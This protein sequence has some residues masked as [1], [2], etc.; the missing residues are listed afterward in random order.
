MHVRMEDGISSTLLRRLQSIQNAAALGHWSQDVRSHDTSATRTSLAADPPAHCV[1]VVTRGVQVPAQCCTS[2]SRQRL[3]TGIVIGQETTTAFLCQR[4]SGQSADKNC[5]WSSRVQSVRPC[6]V[7]RPVKCRQNCVL[8]LCVL[9]LSGNNWKLACS[10]ALTDSA[11]DDIRRLFILRYTKCA[12]WLID[13]LLTSFSTAVFLYN[14][15]NSQN[16]IQPYV[17][18]YSSTCD[19]V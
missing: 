9:T 7:E 2:L 8:L 10:R 16:I 4:H 3:R 6:D 1:Q 18:H 17:R 19:H 5:S 14:N 11:L 12:Y 15:T 13:W